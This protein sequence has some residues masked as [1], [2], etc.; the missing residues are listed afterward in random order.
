MLKPRSHLD[1]ITL[2]EGSQSLVR[3]RRRPT[4]PGTNEAGDR[5]VFTPGSGAAEPGGAL[6]GFDSASASIEP[7]GELAGF[8][9]ASASIEPEGELAG[10]AASGGGEVAANVLRSILSLLAMRRSGKPWTEQGKDH[11]YHGHFEQFT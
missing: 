4:F 9:S 6:A 3:P 2:R 10:F 11:F 5:S 7:E 1:W 8:D